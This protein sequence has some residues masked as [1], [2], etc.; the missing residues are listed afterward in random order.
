MNSY[1]TGEEAGKKEE[2][3]YLQSL[4]CHAKDAGFYS[5]GFMSKKVIGIRSIS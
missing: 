4:E 2:K 1:R 3:Q 5:R